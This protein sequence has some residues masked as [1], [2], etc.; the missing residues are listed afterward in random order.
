MKSNQTD[1]LAA[2]LAV[3]ADLLRGDRHS[4]RTIAQSTGKSLPT[5]D[6]WIEHIQHAFPHIRRVRDGKTTWL[7]HEGRRLPSTSTAVGACV[8]ASLGS[9]FEGSRQERNLKDARDYILRERGETYGDLD[10]KFVLAARGGEHALPEHGGML[11]HL[12]EAVLQSRRLRVEY[13]HNDG[14][15]EQMKIEPLSL[16]IYENKFYVLVERGGGF[17]PYRFARFTRVQVTD[18]SFQ[19]PPKGQYDPQGLFAQ[20]F[21]IHIYDTGPAETIEVILREPWA[22]YALTHRWHPSQRA[23]MRD[24]GCSARVTLRVPLCRELETWILSFGECATIVQPEALRE[25]IIRRLND[26]AVSY[27]PKPTMPLVVKTRPRH[28]EHAKNAGKAR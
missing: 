6:R 16:V 11:D 22:S 8:A 27:T 25:T 9:I 3:V 20:S 24:D 17:Y 5:A 21:G 19:Y 13:R 2:L 10:R 14:R 7:V 15:E 1:T 4:R 12:V 18:E 28:T 26:A 23:S